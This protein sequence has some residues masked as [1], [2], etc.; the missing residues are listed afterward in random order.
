MNVDVRIFEELIVDEVA[1]MGEKQ[2]F[3]FLGF[4]HVS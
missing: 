4:V 3:S 2:M 1:V